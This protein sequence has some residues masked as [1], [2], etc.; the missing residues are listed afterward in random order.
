M[1]ITEVKCRYI[2]ILIISLKEIYN[3]IISFFS[4]KISSL[5]FIVNFNKFKENYLLSWGGDLSL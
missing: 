3:P 1:L 4:L 2:L 5:F